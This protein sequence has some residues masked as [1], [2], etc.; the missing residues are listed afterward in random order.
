MLDSYSGMPASHF[1]FLSMA[2]A[3]A[4]GGPPVVREI[5]RESRTGAP[6][7]RRA[8]SG[9]WTHLESSPV[10]TIL[11]PDRRSRS[12]LERQQQSRGGTCGPFH[13]VPPSIARISAD[14]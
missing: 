4:E 13:E 10:R 7:V 14:H 5:G 1:D 6:S 12:S 8:V 2:M 9:A 3:R 11:D